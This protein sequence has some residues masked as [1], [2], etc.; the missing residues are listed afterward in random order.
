MDARDVIARAMVRE[1][2]RDDNRTVGTRDVEVA[3]AILAALRDAGLAVVPRE[4]T[5]SMMDAGLYQ[6]SADAEWS[7]VNSMWKD[8]LSAYERD[9]DDRAMLAAAA[10]ERTD[11]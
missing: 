1:Y 7:D 2:T 5:R 4:P 10:M 9:G 3:D 8:M 11:D 6:S